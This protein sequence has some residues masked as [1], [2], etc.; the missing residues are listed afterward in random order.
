VNDHIITSIV[1][2]CEALGVQI[3]VEGVETP[4][5]LQRFRNH[6]CS[7]FQG[8]ISAGRCPG[9]RTWIISAGAGMRTCGG[10]WTRRPRAGEDKGDRRRPGPKAARS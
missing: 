6:R 2:L 7:L 9:R 1:S 8:I 5:Q 3:V 4:E 10:N